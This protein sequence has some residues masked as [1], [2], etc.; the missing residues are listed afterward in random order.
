MANF[1]VFNGDAFSLTS[2]SGV[3]DKM[4][5]KPG[6]LGELGLFEAMPVSTQTVWIDRRE[7][8]L[9]LIPTS[10]TGA[11]P[12]ELGSDGRD[13]VALKAHRLAKGATIYAAEIAGWRAFGSESEQERVMKEYSRKME[14]VRRDVELTQEHMRLGALQGIVYDA[15]GSTELYNYYTQFGESAAASTSFELDDNTTDV[16]G[17]CHAIT[18]SMARSS[19]GA[20]NT[21]TTVHALAG[22]DFYDALIVHPQVRETYLNWS[23]AADLRGNSA[24]GSFTYGGITFHNYRGTDDNNAVAIAANEVKLFPVGADGVFKHVMAPAD[25]FI[26]YVGAPGQNVYSMNLRDPSGR[27]A[28]VRNE[29][30][31]YPLFVCTRP[32]VLRSGTLT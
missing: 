1:D 21:G 24:F 28:W 13:A 14:R 19:K 7:D 22:D 30:Y 4:D 29:Q 6:L 8:G 32:S 31:S 27:D 15:D 12:E 11:A 26:P 3:V 20:F 10:V 17:V 23:A 16:R 25:E 2:L 9:N 18:R 5:Y